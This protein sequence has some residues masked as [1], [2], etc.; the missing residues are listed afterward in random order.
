M[1]SVNSGF[2]WDDGT[3]S[4]NINQDIKRRKVN[5]DLKQDSASLQ[6]LMD[7]AIECCI[8]YESGENEIRVVVQETLDEVKAE[9]VKHLYLIGFM[10]KKGS[11]SLEEYAAQVGREAERQCRRELQ[12]IAKRLVY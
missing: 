4:L 9:K 5:V 7:N 11:L 10:V 6:V 3:R 1:E 2:I 8:E 12:D